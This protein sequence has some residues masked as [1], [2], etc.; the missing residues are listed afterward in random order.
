MAK[1][2]L[3]LVENTERDEQNS[4][5]FYAA[6]LKKKTIKRKWNISILI[7]SSVNINFNLILKIHINVFFVSNVHAIKKFN[8][9]AILSYVNDLHYYYYIFIVKCNVYKRCIYGRSDFLKS[10]KKTKVIRF[11]KK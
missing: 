5:W 2:Q 1:N 8:F 9:K 11:P 10:Y 7:K 3:S 6:Q 4:V